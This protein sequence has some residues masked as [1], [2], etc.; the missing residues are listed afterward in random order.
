MNLRPHDIRQAANAAA[1]HDFYTFAQMMYAETNGQ[2]FETNWHLEAI[3]HHLDLVASGAITRLLI[4]VPPRSLK[5]TLCSV[6]LP[7]FLLGRDPRKKIICA[8]YSDRLAADLSR[9]S[10]RVMETARY[11]EVF[12]DRLSRSTKNSESYFVTNSGGFRYSTSVGATLTGMGGSLIIIDDPMNAVDAHSSTALG[13]TER[14]FRETVVS[15]LDDKR[16]DAMVIIMQRLNVADL[17][18]FVL[19]QG[20]WQHL[21]LPAIAVESQSIPLGNSR[22]HHRSAGDVLHSAR[23]DISAL[24]SHKK[25]LGTFG[26]EAQYQQRPF[27][28]QGNLVKRDWLQRYDRIE[29]FP[30]DRVILSIDPAMTLGEQSS[31]SAIVVMLQRGEDAFL[32]DVKRFRCEFPELL[33]RIKELHYRY[34]RLTGHY[35]LLVE[36]GG[37]GIA[38]S[39][40]LKLDGIRAIEIDPE[41]DKFVRLN[42]QCSRIEAGHLFLPEQAE[43]LDDF[44]AELLSFPSGKF[45]DQVD[46]FSQALD[47]IFFRKGRTGRAF[48]SAYRF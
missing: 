10:K 46:A 3:A 26:F 33:K 9:Q 32:Y 44:E 2:S 34:S 15:R 40:A 38:L 18:G 36:K 25:L 37:G 35:E 19:Q 23:E 12:G 20:G 24:E 16:K 6:M 11:R 29:V 13:K 31:Y 27:P 5:S 7:A 39:Q 17:A 21:D 45:D 42:R 28:A 8:S 48:L 22:V 1:R 14:W 30:N 43:W 4:T 41:G 47:R